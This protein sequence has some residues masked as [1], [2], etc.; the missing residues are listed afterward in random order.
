LFID[1]V[2]A[3]GRIGCEFRWRI[4]GDTSF[5]AVEGNGKYNIM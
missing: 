5:E 3:I 4:M 2:R 1:E